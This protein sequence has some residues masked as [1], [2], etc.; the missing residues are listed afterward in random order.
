MTL[1]RV[2]GSL[3]QARRARRY[4]AFSERARDVR[5]AQEALLVRLVAR[6]GHTAL[7]RRLGADRVRSLDDLR[8]LVPITDYDAI[9]PELQAALAGRPDQLVAGCPPFFAMT[10]G[11]T[12]FAKY[13]PID[14]AYR[15]EFQRTLD[16]F[17]YAIVRDHPAALAHKALYLVGPATLETT[18]GGTPAGTI[19]GYNLRR[20]S[21]LLRRFYA[22]PADAFEIPAPDSQLYTIARFCLAHELSIAFSVTTA[23]LAALGRT[24]EEHADAL[25]RDIHDGTLSAPELP[26]PLRANLGRHLRR[27]PARAR[28]LTARVAG[29]RLIPK[30]FFPTL[31]LVSCWHHASAGTHLA[32]LYD[33]FGELPL[34]PA[35]YSATEGWLNVPL[36]DAAP[37]QPPSGVLACD[38]VVVEFIDH[39][40]VPRFAHELHRPGRYELL[41]TSGAGLWRYRLGDEVEVTGF[42]D[43][44]SPETAA[45][46]GKA[47]LFHYVQKTGAVVSI[48]H[49][50]TT[51]SHVRAAVHAALPGHRRFVFGPS[52]SAPDRYRVALERTPDLEAALAPL[53]ASLDAALRA[54]NLGYDADRDSGVIGPLE[55]VVREHEHFDAWERARQRPV[56]AQSKPTVFVKSPSEHLP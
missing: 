56:I 33:A 49:D 55:L 28:L 50:M 9:Q 18:P 23:P 24:I 7:A 8:R 20:L 1:Q 25:L 39:A 30:H 37:D 17:L 48:A 3:L 34:R 29:K 22:V 47:P 27:D 12:G 45:P 36:A 38:A 19:S 26:S 32:A 16:P 44:L 40:G 41:I 54:A 51:E 35:I 21:P 11:T 42:F 53:A 15:A 10:S 31:R 13:V 5:P 6:N 52:P 43:A 14:D 4:H 46:T 2:L